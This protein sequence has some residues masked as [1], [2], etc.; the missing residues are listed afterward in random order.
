MKASQTT[1]AKPL[2]FTWSVECQLQLVVTQLL[3]GACPATALCIVAAQH[4]NSK[5][6][7]GNHRKE[8]PDIWLTASTALTAPIRGSNMLLMADKETLWAGQ[9]QLYTASCHN[10]CWPMCA[11]NLAAL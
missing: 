11:A 4:T 8:L 1:N 9:Q 10:F 2:R 7:D 3:H 6:A 5:T